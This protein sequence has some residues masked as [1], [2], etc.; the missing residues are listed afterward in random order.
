MLHE[1]E[2][3]LIRVSA[4]RASVAQATMSLAVASAQFEV[5]SWEMLSKLASCLV[6]LGLEVAHSAKLAPSPLPAPSASD[7]DA[8]CCTLVSEWTCCSEETSI[9]WLPIQSKSIGVRFNGGHGESDAVSCIGLND[10]K[11]RLLNICPWGD[12]SEKF[13]SCDLSTTAFLCNGSSTPWRGEG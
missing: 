7:P 9:C 10:E 13:A 2:L 11:S 5:D 6:Q 1:P 12:K 3:K 8:A 4:A